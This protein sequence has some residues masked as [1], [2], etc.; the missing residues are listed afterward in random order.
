MA[1]LKIA[2]LAPV[3]LLLQRLRMPAKLG[4][5]G[6]LLMLPLLWLT[7]SQLRT[8]SSTSQAL[9]AEQDGAHTVAA[10]LQL[11]AQVQ[12]HRDLTQR[13]LSGDAAAQTER[14][15]VRQQLRQSAL[16]VD[17]LIDTT[18]T[19]TM[20]EAWR[21]LREHFE[22]LA[23]GQRAD[24][25]DE[26]I[27][28]H[29][30]IV[31]DARRLIF[32]VS[33]AA[34]LTLDADAASNLLVDIVSNRLVSF[35]ESLG[36][37]RGVGATVLT[38]GEISARERLSL[39]GAVDDIARQIEEMALRMAALERSGNAVPATWVPARTSA[40]TLAQRTQTIFSSM[41]LQAEPLAFYTEASAA[42]DAAA[43]LQ[44]QLVEA[45][46]D[47]LA[48][49]AQASAWQ[50][51]VAVA[52]SI[53]SIA[54]LSYFGAAFYLSFHGS[55]QRMHRGI[56]IIAGGDL[57]HRIV[58]P[59]RDEMAEIGAMVERMNERMSS[60]V[61]E[62]RSS[63]ARVGMAG[64]EVADGSAALSLRT[65]EQAA[66]LRQTLATAQALS[67]AVASN[68]QAAG[69]LDRLI[70]ALAQDAQTGERAMH[71]SSAAM[72]ELQTGSQRMAEITAVIDGI[73]FQTNILALN[74]AVEAAR[75]G[76]AGRGFAVVAAEVRQLAQRSA[77]AAG[78]IKQLI[79]Q[80]SQ[81]VSASVA[82]IEHVAQVLSALVQGVY[83]ASS[84]LRAIAGASAQQSADLEQV[85]QG[86]VNLDGITQRNADMVMH[87][88][89]AAQ[90]LV[91]RAAALNGAVA[92][93]RLRQG[94]ADEA[95]ALVA[96][97]RHLL[98][99]V[100]LA[101]ASAEL[102]SADA[103]FVDRD[104]YIFVIDR[105]G[106]YRL[107]GAKPAM[108]G[109]RVHELPGIDGDRFV[110][111]AWAAVESGGGWIN[112]DIVN[113]QSG[114]VQGKS[115]YVVALGRDLFIGCGVYRHDDPAAQ[116]RSAG[117]ASPST[118]PPPR[119]PGAGAV[120]AESA[121]VKRSSRL[122]ARTT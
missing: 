95:A 73:A 4:L 114:A 108:E 14:D 7:L 2:L 21:P 3:A 53:G 12:A 60:M 45:L 16:A 46:L 32:G 106:T 90:D 8:L 42:I 37:V 62:I 110:R 27:A 103:G 68:S 25:R 71:D 76:E 80:S 61:A 34:T 38:R 9:H 1:R 64:K 91:A 48:R 117:I 56:D 109:H 116:W 24:R 118:A 98:K 99:S 11:V 102:H 79:A 122:L 66:T 44:G 107:H 89:H 52:L 26:S 74:A 115:S 111:D 87:S 17:A 75:A 101:A 31:D 43:A 67:H 29:R 36:A 69:E 104:L 47:G 81:R 19:F 93:M 22:A 6:A 84:A 13:V 23:S 92:S 51:C 30:R 49:R 83:T 15:A 28:Q 105:A 59:G 88:S 113:P 112:Y 20:P 57:T 94:S 72:G 82:R 63:A 10:L 119:S 5:L 85:T 78:E 18:Q 120:G 40:Q 55:L 65:E 96:R 70:S 41:A 77:T 54:L 100:G 58:I 97:A 39:L 121:A 86:I 33:Q 35:S 50:L